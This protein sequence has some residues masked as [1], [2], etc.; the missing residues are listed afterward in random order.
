MLCCLT[1]LILRDRKVIS[2]GAEAEEKLNLRLVS[3]KLNTH[4]FF[5]PFDTM[6]PRPVLEHCLG[7]RPFVFCSYRVSTRQPAER[8]E[9]RN[10]P[11]E[12]FGSSFPSRRWFQAYERDIS[13]HFLAV[14]FFK[15]S[16]T[17]QL[18]ISVDILLLD[19]SQAERRM[20]V[21]GI[22]QPDDLLEHLCARH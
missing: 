11:D 19:R 4:D 21:V 15:R 20:R 2:A 22:H 1:R 10:G 12:P 9:I 13:R 7:G 14:H 6:S 8:R 17:R 3:H 16:K 18:H 5:N